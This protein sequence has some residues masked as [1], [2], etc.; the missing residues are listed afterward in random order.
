MHTDTTVARTMIAAERRRLATPEYDGFAEND[1]VKALLRL[2]A[3]E[4]RLDMLDHP[5][6]QTIDPRLAPLAARIDRLAYRQ[7]CGYSQARARQIAE[8]TAAYDAIRAGEGN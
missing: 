7:R 5:V 6:I 1:R 3:E 4:G 8:F 2:D